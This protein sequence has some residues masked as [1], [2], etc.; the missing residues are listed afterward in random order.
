MRYEE[1]RTILTVSLLL[2]TLAL[3]ARAQLQVGDNA[4]MNLNGNVSFGYSGGFSNYGP[5]THT[6]SPSGNADLSGYYYS[7]GFVSFDVQ[8]FY[9]Q[10]RANSAYR[11][12]FQT[13][14]VS[15]NTSIFSG[16]HF[17]GTVSYS[18]VYNSE[19]GFVVPGV[20]N[21]TTRGNSNSLA[22]GWGIQIPDYPRVAVLFSDGGN[23]SSLYGSGAD[24]NFH[25]RTY[26]VNALHKWEGFNI[27]GGYHHNVVDTLTPEFLVGQEP[28]TS[29]ASSN[30][31]DVSATHWLP[32]HGSFSIGADHAS[33]DSEAAGESYTA[34]IETVSSGVGF[35][36][37][38]NL[39]VGAN[40]QYTNNLS[41]SLYQSVITSGGVVPPALLDYSTHALDVNTQGS[42]MI[43]RWHLTFMANADHREQS[44]RGVPI[45]GNTFS[46]SATYGNTF[47]RG[48]MTLSAGATQTSVS[49][50]NSVDSRGWFGNASYLRK[51][52]RW[53][54]SGSVNYSRNSQTAF[55]GYT[56]SGYGY[57]AA[58]GRKFHIYS[59][60]SVNASGSKSTFNVGGS[61]NSAQSY[62]TALSLRHFSISG[63]YGKANGI[64]ILTPGG[65]TPITNPGV[66]ISPLDEIVFNA[67]T[68]S[69][70]MSTTP[71]HGLVLSGTYSRTRSNTFASL[72]DSRNTTAQIN[73]MLQYRLRQLWITGGYLKLQQDFTITGLPA[74]S[75]SSFFIGIT[76][77]FNFF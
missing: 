12:I 1:H 72:A 23:T 30:T 77:W 27:N 54:F 65:L 69:A 2:L 13:G 44:M 58:I 52:D 38:T 15:A 48:F 53:S 19:G 62:S 32:L 14:G 5:S 29:H 66:G 34:S 40:A 36:P 70:G 6:L 25:T 7:P 49:A 46:Q 57:T 26:G 28:L 17:P 3:P 68:Y 76:R 67:K 51:L 47:L 20:G 24:A 56:S 45:S 43:P 41:G 10:S 42:Y 71:V 50:L 33:V 37:V 55:I 63:S 18:K 61:D 22:I 39:N 75:D 35:Q 73:T 11:S 60:W 64:S 16:S 9:N 4:S 21:L 74:T 59:F 8:P 31:F